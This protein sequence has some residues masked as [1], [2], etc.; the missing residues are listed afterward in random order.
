MPNRQKQE[1]QKER[2]L[3]RSKVYLPRGNEHHHAQWPLLQNTAGSWK[4]EDLSRHRAPQ[5]KQEEDQQV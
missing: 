3:P 2:E 1:F 4:D 5:K